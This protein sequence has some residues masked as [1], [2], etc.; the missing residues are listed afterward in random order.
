MLVVIL[1]GADGSL[2][3]SPTDPNQSVFYN[4][5]QGNIDPVVSWAILAVVVVGS[6]R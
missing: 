6:A 5:V 4:L 1:G 2:S 3:V